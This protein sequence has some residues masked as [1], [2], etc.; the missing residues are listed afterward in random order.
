CPFLW[1]TARFR[2]CLK[3]IIFDKVVLPFQRTFISS[4][5]VVTQDTQLSYNWQFCKRVNFSVRFRGS[6][7]LSQKPI[8]S[9]FF[10]I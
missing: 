6:N 3:P 9:C 1:G 4:Y 2:L 8:S 5:P 10:V 7:Y